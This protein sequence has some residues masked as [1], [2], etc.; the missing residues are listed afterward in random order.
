[1]LGSIQDVHIGQSQNWNNGGAKN[2][3]N[4]ANFI[5]QHTLARL[6]RDTGNVLTV[7]KVDDGNWGICERLRGRQR[8]GHT[9]VHCL[10]VAVKDAAGVNGSVRVE[11]ALPWTISVKLS[12]GLDSLYDRRQ[13][14][15]GVIIW[16]DP[17]PS[18]R[19]QNRPVLLPVLDASPYTQQIWSA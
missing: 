7:A 5:E 13:Q 9:P 14:G 16:R 2:V 4:G 1:M 10:W 12:G 11:D 15:C 18:M 3:S 8:G 6:L 19:S 17:S